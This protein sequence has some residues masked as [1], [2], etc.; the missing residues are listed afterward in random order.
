MSISRF[1]LD[2]EK[3]MIDTLADTEYLEVPHLHMLLIGHTGVGKTSVRK[4]LQNIPFNDKEKST[5]IM[6]QELLY[7]RNIRKYNR[8]Q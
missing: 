4:H 3:T 8:L 5:I 2:L 7:P 6:E 1:T